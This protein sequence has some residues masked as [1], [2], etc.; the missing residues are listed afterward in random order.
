MRFLG[1]L[2]LAGE[3]QGKKQYVI[4]VLLET[5][6]LPITF[7]LSDA[8]DQSFFRLYHDA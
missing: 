6:G 4:F 2:W 8:R 3:I 7:W 1:N 5:V